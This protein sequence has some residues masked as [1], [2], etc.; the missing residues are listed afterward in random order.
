MKGLKNGKRSKGRARSKVTGFMGMPKSLFPARRRGVMAYDNTFTISCA[1]STTTS[2]LFRANSV[3][4]PDFSGVGTTVAGYSQMATVYTRY[5]VMSV[6]AFVSSQVSSG[7]P[8]FLY[9]HASNQ[10]FAP[11]NF[12]EIMAQ[13]FVY[14]KALGTPSGVAI[15][16]HRVS[17][18]IGAIYGV[19]Q[20]T[21]MAEDDFTGLTSGHPNNPV[22]LHIGLLASGSTTTLFMNVR[23]EYDVI[24]DVPINVPY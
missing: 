17:F 4:D 9:I 20:S 11:T 6:K 10:N 14:K 24:W 8:G 2:N 13:R 15:D 1:A 7:G 12:S 18:P 19:P 23:I 5:R 16:E 3:F 21:V 22:F